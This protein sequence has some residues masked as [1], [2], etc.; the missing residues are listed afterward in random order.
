MYISVIDSIYFAHKDMVFS[1][2]AILHLI[3]ITCISY[4]I[5]FIIFLPKFINIAPP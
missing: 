4:A 3:M 1:S 5:I 2:L